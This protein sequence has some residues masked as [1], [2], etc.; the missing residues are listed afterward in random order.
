MYC[1]NIQCSLHEPGEGGT[2]I[3]VKA[4]C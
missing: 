2:T 1:I 4:M 3:L